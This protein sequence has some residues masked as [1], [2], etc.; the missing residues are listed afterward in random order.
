MKRLDYFE[1]LAHLFE[2]KLIKDE[3]NNEYIVFKQSRLISISGIVDKTEFEAL[4][5]HVH[6][7][8]RVRKEEFGRLISIGEIIGSAVLCKLKSQFSD[9]HFIVYVSTTLNDSMILRFHQKWDGELP[10]IPVD[11]N[12]PNEKVLKFEC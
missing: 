7:L 8:A 1:L 3:D 10:Y 9:K 12:A 11:F 2:F 5:N 6:L 4:E